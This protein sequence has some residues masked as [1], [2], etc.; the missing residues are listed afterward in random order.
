VD[1]FVSIRVCLATYRRQVLALGW[2]CC[3]Q[4]PQQTLPDHTCVVVEQDDLGRR[5]IYSRD[6][7][8]HDVVIRIGHGEICPGSRFT[9]VGSERTSRLVRDDIANMGYV[10]L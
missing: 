5:G 6:A 1:Y 7:G 2:F 4:L 3:L 9:D 10:Q 8:S